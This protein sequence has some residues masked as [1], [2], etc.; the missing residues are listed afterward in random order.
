VAEGLM[1]SGIQLWW[2]EHLSRTVLRAGLT[3]I[4]ELSVCME[5]FA[6]GS[7][8]AGAAVGDRLTGAIEETPHVSPA[9]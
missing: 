5:F 3:R 1:R 6:A 9:V 4:S 8:A 2:L 7:R